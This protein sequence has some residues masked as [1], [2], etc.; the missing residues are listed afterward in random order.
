MW[1]PR[2]LVQSSRNNVSMYMLRS[3]GDITPPCLTPLDIL[4]V[5]EQLLEQVT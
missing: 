5:L 4:H 3:N 2:P 1:Q